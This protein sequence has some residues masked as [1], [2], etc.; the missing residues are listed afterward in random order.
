MVVNCQRLNLV[1]SLKRLLSLTCKLLVPEWL[2]VCVYMRYVRYNS[3][4]FACWL[5]AWTHTSCNEFSHIIQEPG[6]QCTSF[7]ALWFIWRPHK[8]HSS[9]S[10]Q[11]LLTELKCLN[12]HVHAQCIFFAYMSLV[13]ILTTILTQ[14]G[15]IHS[16]VFVYIV[17]Y[18]Y[19]HHITNVE[20][21]WCTHDSS[22]P[23]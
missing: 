2:H 20:Y 5:H 15:V 12:V 13:L 4:I 16:L 3:C 21:F 7:A 14:S 8:C 11:R 9:V 22:F 10:Y 23:H 17:V 6:Q 19:M 1:P 18:Y